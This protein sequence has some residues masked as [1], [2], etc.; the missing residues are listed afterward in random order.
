M[1]WIIERLEYH[2]GKNANHVFLYD[3]LTPKG[4]DYARFYELSGRIYAYLKAKGVGR[5]DFVLINLPRGVQ[6]VVAM[7]GVWR[8]GAAFAL[9]EDTYAPERIDFIRKDC[10]CKIELN[11]A[12]LDEAMR[13][14]PLTG[15]EDVGDHDAAYAIYTSGT[16]GNPKGV[17]HEY[18]N[19]REAADSL[20]YNG[21]DLVPGDER[22][23]LA[24]PLNFVA[25][26][27]VLIKLI[28]LESPRLWIISY[29]TVKNPMKLG[30][31]MLEKR[32]ACTFLT[33]SYVRALGTKTGPFLK[34][35]IVGSEPANGISPG[36]LDVTNGYAMS[37]SGF[38]VTLFKIDK[39]Y[40]TCPIGRPQLPLK[41][42]LLGEDGKE[43]PDGEM[44]EFCFDN[45]HVRG[46]INLPE[47][48]AR[49][50]VNGVYHTG[51]LAM[52]L[53]SG[54]YVLLGRSNDMVKINGNRIEPAE[55]EAAV[56]QV[57]GV[58]WCAVRGFEDDEQAFLAA[59]YTADIPKPNSNAVREAL[60]R[61]LPYY[62][63][64]Q[65]FVKIDK[66]PLKP[67]GKMDRKALPKPDTSDY[68]SDYVAP[69]N[70][71]EKALCQAMATA[72]R[73][74]RIGVNDDFYELGGDSLGAMQVITGSGLKGLTAS[75]LFR[76][77]T[78][79]KIAELY[80][81]HHA[82]NDA[83]DF[84]EK[85]SKSRQ[86]SHPLTVEQSY[87]VDYQL[88]TPKSTMYNLFA[89][90]KVEKGLFES[91]KLAEAITTVLRAHPS[92]A[93]VF[94]FDDDG[95]IRQGYH[96]E[97]IEEVKVEKI[98]EFDFSL[99]KDDLVKPYKIIGSRLYRCR[100][101]ETEKAL[102]LF[103]DVHHT[104]FDGTS[105]KVLMG[106]IAKA[107]MGEELETDFYYLM[108]AN[109]EAA[110]NSPFYAESRDY[111][112]K[113]YGGD[114]WICRPATD[115]E[116]RDNAA[117]EVTCP[118]DISQEQMKLA[119]KAFKVSRNEFFIAAFGIAFALK[120]NAK[121]VKFS[122]IYNGRE[123]V[124]AMSTCGLLFRDLPAGFR[125]TDEMDVRDI[126][127]SAATQ[128]SKAIEHSCYPYVD[129]T[130]NVV[131]DDVPY[132]LYQNDIHD[133]GIADGMAFEQITVRQNNAASQTILDVE[134]LDG[135]EGLQLAVHYAASRYER[136]T[137]ERF[138]DLFAAVCRLLATHTDQAK[139]TFADI[140]TAILGK[141]SFWQRL[142]HSL[143]SNR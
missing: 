58:E 121:N 95:D 67:N 65:Y 62:M 28:D 10:S 122:W 91:V 19:L 137:I 50:F 1:N 41:I 51:D 118:L 16:T 101:F 33:P 98:S 23:L 42:H 4:L 107:Y 135:R 108:L 36:K 105:F 15:Y 30:L 70:D 143:T 92:L 74:R 76:G 119:E 48:T 54:D 124:E 77:R 93:T 85:D 71:T 90:V 14:E 21:G 79:A 31:F 55:V 129:K 46:Y 57:L 97:I 9:V 5:E 80:L 106:D 139:L 112:E 88:Y 86:G 81:A 64:P 78:P 53:P 131:E 73:L 96:P 56:K 69:R 45:P 34:R 37:E 130:L 127:A 63:L 3:E 8:A 39:A 38:I 52:K 20:T 49:A 99:L 27:I 83:E 87:M 29:A 7:F 13:C 94:S 66:V 110:E 115:H 26:T 136:A 89:T 140:R 61:R 128:V 17:L 12:A 134:V 109:R 102:Y 133:A 125:L 114:D 47:E 40:D 116:T 141:P 44:G 72:L 32:I 104:V 126:F 123:D 103:F 142:F 25:S 120:E 24:A 100:L 111:F 84:A 59:Y 18:G 75:D 132:I 6:P 43:V 117:G 35:L 60:S 2:L 11:S 113:T 68:V 82:H 138:R 22:F